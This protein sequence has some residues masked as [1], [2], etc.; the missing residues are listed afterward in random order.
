[1]RTTEIGASRRLH[2]RWDDRISR[3]QVHGTFAEEDVRWP[4]VRTKDKIIDFKLKIEAGPGENMPR[5]YV[6]DGVLGVDSF[7]L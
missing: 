7:K 4:K 2:M 1:M 6:V 5:E 3:L